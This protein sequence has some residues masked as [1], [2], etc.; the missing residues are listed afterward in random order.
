MGCYNHYSGITSNIGE[1]YNSLIKMMTDRKELGADDIS[2][3]L[4]HLSIYH[5]NEILRGLCGKGNYYFIFNN[6]FI[7]L[8]QYW[9]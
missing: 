4:Y 2:V 9:P 3:I 6:Y 8:I 1:G 7:I 5:Y